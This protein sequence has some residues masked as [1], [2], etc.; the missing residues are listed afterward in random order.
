MRIGSV[1][2]GCS[3]EGRGAGRLQFGRA[4]WPVASAAVFVV[5]IYLFEKCRPI[6]NATIGKII[7]VISHFHSVLKNDSTV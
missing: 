7:V 5:P 6:K 2:E 3:P 4:G 1:D